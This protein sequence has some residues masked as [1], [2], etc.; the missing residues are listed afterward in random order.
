MR[1]S[2]AYALSILLVLAALVCVVLAV[3]YYFAVLQ[4]L[5]SDPKAHNHPT[6]AIVFMVAAVACLIAANIARPKK[7]PE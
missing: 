3:L 2:S 7:L 6:H 1:N 5:V 4:I